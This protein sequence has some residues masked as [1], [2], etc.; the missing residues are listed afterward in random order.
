MTD[1]VDHLHLSSMRT[2]PRSWLP[3]SFLFWIGSGQRI[4]NNSNVGY[5]S[6]LFCGI[7][8]SGLLLISGPIRTGTFNILPKSP[9][10][11][12][13]H[14]K[15]IEYRKVL[16]DFCRCLILGVDLISTVSKGVEFLGG[17]SY[18]VK[19]YRPVQEQ[20]IKDELNK[21]FHKFP[22]VKTYGS[23]EQM[24]ITTDYMVEQEG[25]AA[26]SVVLSKLFVG[27]K[28]FLPADA[29]PKEFT[30]TNKYVQQSKK[31][32]A[33][34][35]DDLKAGA[36]KA[37][38]F[39]II[40]IFLIYCFDSAIGDTLG[41]VALLH[42][43]LVTWLFFPILRIS[44]HSLGNWPALHRSHPHRD[45][46]PWMIRLVWQIREAA[47]WKNATKGEIIN[48][49]INDT[50]VVIMTSLTNLTIL[51]FS[52]VGGEVTKGFAFA[53]LIGVITD[54]F[55]IFVAPILVDGKDKPLG[56]PIP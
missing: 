53:M 10:S 1:T 56:R 52:L 46:S 22:E 13:G 33:S 15:F 21:V 27:L 55:F 2:W 41:T 45:P 11:L 18:V 26:D 30:S 28:S 40:T 31:V 12:S 23:N 20:P 6:F 4:C 19:F 24:E 51:F 38:V 3:Q 16:M 50:L 37:T 25:E 43:V 32:T 29:N 7:L 47:G 5:C 39:A 8:V 9:E 54:L 49:A 14:F 35:S 17:R 36:V 44:C 48:K 34:I 42:D